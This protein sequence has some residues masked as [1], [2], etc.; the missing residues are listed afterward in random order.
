MS[1]DIH[2]ICGPVL[3]GCISYP[4]RKINLIF[5]FFGIRLQSSGDLTFRFIYVVY[6][7]VN[8]RSNFTRQERQEI[9]RMM[10]SGLHHCY[11]K[12]LKNF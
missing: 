8:V 5:W 7:V 2:I 1:T 4:K 10:N 6:F 11:I 9:N 3:L 12:F